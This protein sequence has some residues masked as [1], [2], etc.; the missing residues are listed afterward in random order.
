MGV[1]GAQPEVF[2]RE[3]IVAEDVEPLGPA[4]CVPTGGR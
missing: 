1:C 3:G 2:D 4:R